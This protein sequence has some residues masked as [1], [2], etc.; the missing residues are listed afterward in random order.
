LVI[1]ASARMASSCFFTTTAQLFAYARFYQVQMK[2]LFINGLK[3]Q[4]KNI[5]HITLIQAWQNWRKNNRNCLI[6]AII[7]RQDLTFFLNS[8]PCKKYVGAAAR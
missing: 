2:Q 3:L 7:I 4:K 6:I 5:P 8:K 1:N